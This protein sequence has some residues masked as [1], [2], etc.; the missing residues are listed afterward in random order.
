MTVVLPKED[1][2]TSLSILAGELAKT[3]IVSASSKLGYHTDSVQTLVDNIESR[4]S[5]M[6]LK[7]SN[8]SLK[9]SA[10]DG[11]QTYAVIT[12]NALRDAALRLGYSDMEVNDKIGVEKVLTTPAPL[13]ATTI[14]INN[15]VNESEF[16]IEKFDAFSLSDTKIRVF[17]D[18]YY[19]CLTA[20]SEEITKSVINSALNIIA[21]DPV[22]MLHNDYTSANKVDSQYEI[23]LKTTAREFVDDVLIYAKRVVAK[24]HHNE[25]VERKKLNKKKKMQ[26]FA[27]KYSMMIIGSAAKQIGYSDKAILDALFKDIGN[28]SGKLHYIGEIPIPNHLLINSNRVSYLKGKHFCVF[29][30]SVKLSSAKYINY[31][32]AAKSIPRNFHEFQITFPPSIMILCKPIKCCITSF[33]QETCTF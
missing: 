17:G 26:N 5:S 31:F 24:D 8:Y 32:L 12:H 25:K 30:F 3:A 16:L 28:K 21:N 10:S 2:D 6:S 15:K 22:K 7:V 1:S 27:L 13:S 29:G 11:E 18:S 9:S 33:N 23:N 19:E 20:A 14:T 4:M